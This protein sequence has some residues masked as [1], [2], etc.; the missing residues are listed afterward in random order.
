[1]TEYEVAYCIYAISIG[2]KIIDLE[3]LERPKSHSC[4]KVL[5]S[6]PVCNFSIW[7]VADVYNKAVLCERNYTMPL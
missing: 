5:R 6:P 2:A 7:T 4:K 1:M 3:D